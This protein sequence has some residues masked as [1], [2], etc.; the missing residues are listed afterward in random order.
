ME[1]QEKREKRLAK[2]RENSKRYYEAHKEEIAEKAKQRRRAKLDAM[3][4]EERTEYNKKQADY[5]R[6]YRA[7]NKSKVAV[8]ALRT[9]QRK[10][11]SILNGQ[12]DATA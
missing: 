3:T 2:L 5:Q 8:W 12:E 4:P 1:D 7:E 10:V 11:E 6:A 9:W